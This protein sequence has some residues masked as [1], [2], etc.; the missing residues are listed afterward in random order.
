[1]K[2]S[3]KFQKIPIFSPI[4]DKICHKKIFD[5]FEF[6][7]GVSCHK[8]RIACYCKRLFLITALQVQL[9]FDMLLR[10]TNILAW[11]AG[12]I[13]N[14]ALSQIEKDDD[15]AKGIQASKVVYVK[16]LRLIRMLGIKGWNPLRATKKKICK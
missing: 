14:S 9:T 6:V 8:R 4:N 1:M 15:L 2:I 16:P 3:K 13:S 10:L 5:L 11:G 7:S 12:F